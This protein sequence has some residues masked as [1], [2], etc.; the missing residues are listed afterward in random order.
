MSQFIVAPVYT[1]LKGVAS[2][3]CLKTP[4]INTIYHWF[5]VSNKKK[6]LTSNIWQNMP[7]STKQV[8]CNIFWP[9]GNYWLD[10]LLVYLHTSPG[11]H[12]EWPKSYL[13]HI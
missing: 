3:Y 12:C 1:C 6:E 7:G 4:M 5:T 9:E 8:S 2:R 10:F 13:R 11:P